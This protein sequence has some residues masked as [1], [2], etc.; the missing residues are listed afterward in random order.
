MTDS[1]LADKTALVV[2]ASRGIGAATARALAAAGASVVLG[3]RDTAAL[4]RVVATIQA[5]GGKAVAVPL[6]VTDEDTISRAVKRA[7]V[8]YGALHVAVNCAGGGPSSL[9]KAA[10][11][12]LPDMSEAL[13]LNFTGTYLAMR[14]EI[15]AILNAGG[16][17]IVNISSRAGL[18]A[19]APG[20]APYVAGKHALQGLTKAAAL[21]YAAQGLRINAIAPGPIDTDLLAAGG[22][23]GRRWAARAVPMGRLGTP[24]EVAAAAVWLA[25]DKASFVCG[26]TLTVDGGMASA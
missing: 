19:P 2:G 15:P 16:G 4:E 8:E 22:D 9:T 26:T 20:T 25:S 5:A 7:V 17:A 1:D 21:D 10:D 6:D 13:A 23:E 18:G 11:V 12:T 14:Q 24:D 3:A